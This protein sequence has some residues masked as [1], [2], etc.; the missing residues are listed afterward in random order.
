[1]ADHP[2]LMLMTISVSVCEVATSKDAMH[3][4]RARH[5]AASTLLC[6]SAYALT[7]LLR[8]QSA[9]AK[10]YI[11]R[12]RADPNEQRSTPS[13][14][15]AC[16]KLLSSDREPSK[17]AMCQTNRCTLVQGGSCCHTGPSE[18]GISA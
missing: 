4:S 12:G 1:M 5:N 2:W 9:E 6:M 17:T 3:C 15:S 10:L 7:E 13:R 18:S 8:V 16:P 11:E 14:Q